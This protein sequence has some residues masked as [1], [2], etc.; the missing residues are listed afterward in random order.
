MLEPSQEEQIIVV[1][2][3]HQK[4]RI[5][6]VPQAA[7]MQ[8]EYNTNGKYAHV[9]PVALHGEVGQ[10][11]VLQQ[12]RLTIRFLPPMTVNSVVERNAILVAVG[13]IQTV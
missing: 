5:A 3:I 7:V 8:G 1:Q 13:F 4:S 11:S 9:Q 6:Q 2:A 12:Q 10:M